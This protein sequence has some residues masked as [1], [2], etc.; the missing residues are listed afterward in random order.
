MM[1]GRGDFM[2]LKIMLA[3][4]FAGTHRGRMYVIVS[5]VASI[6]VSL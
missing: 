6:C 4:S 2:S 1:R 3:L 5:I